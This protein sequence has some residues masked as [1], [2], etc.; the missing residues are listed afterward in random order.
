MPAPQAPEARTSHRAEVARLYEH[1]SPGSDFPEGDFP[2]GDFPDE[3]SLGGVLCH[4]DLPDGYFADEDLAELEA[5]ELEFPEDPGAPESE[6]PQ[7][8][9]AEFYLMLAL[10]GHTVA[11]S[12]L[13]SHQAGT[14]RPKPPGGSVGT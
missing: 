12:S 9:F 3:D 7:D 5:P 4:G 6:L 13:G 8:A 11:E 1:S 10:S 2:E 14:I